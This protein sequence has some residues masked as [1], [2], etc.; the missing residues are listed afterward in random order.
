MTVLWELTAGTLVMAWALA[1]LPYVRPLYAVLAA[2]I[3]MTVVALPEWSFSGVWI[4]TFEPFGVMLPAL[5]AMRLAQASGWSGP[6]PVSR[7]EKLGLAALMLIVLLGAGGALAIH[8][9]AWFYSGLGPALLALGV[10][11]WAL[12]RRQTVV[13]GAVALAQL[14]WLADVGSSNFY[15]HLAHVL[16]VPGLIVSA[17][18]PGRRTA[19]T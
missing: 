19:P 7:F 8:P 12:W 15:D 2:S 18:W 16:L 17:L 3:L 4:A 6:P 10:G 1:W 5:C 11:A 14:L 13:L 9:Y